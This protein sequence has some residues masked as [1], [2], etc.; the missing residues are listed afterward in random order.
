MA[1]WYE[2]AGELREAISHALI[3]PDYSC[4]VALLE[5]AVLPLAQRGRQNEPELDRGGRE[6]LGLED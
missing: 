6:A 3:A 4:S 1:R 5:Q 2:A